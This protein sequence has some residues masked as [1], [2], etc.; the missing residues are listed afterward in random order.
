M[1]QRILNRTRRNKRKAVIASYRRA[2]QSY[3][4]MAALAHNVKPVEWSEYCILMAT[5]RD[6]DADTW[7]RLS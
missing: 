3:R 1:I 4:E 6:N 2:A 5:I 7:E